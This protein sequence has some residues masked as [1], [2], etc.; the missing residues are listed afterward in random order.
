MKYI[1]LTLLSILFATQVI[2]NSPE[3]FTYQGLALD[4]NGNPFVNQNISL[5][6][7]IS[8]D[9]PQG[10]IRYQEIQS[11]TTSSKGIFSVK[12]GKGSATMATFENFASNI[13]RHALFLTIEIDPVGGSNH[14]YMGSMELLSVPFALH[15]TYSL[16]HQGAQGPNGPVGAAGADGPPGILP[17]DCCFGVGCVGDPG[18]QG[19]QG[20]IGP[21]GVPGLAG[22]SNL[23]KTN[24][25]PSNPVNGQLYMDDGS[26]RVDGNIGYRYFDVNQWIDL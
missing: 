2:A 15:A 9:S 21:S 8:R 19:P 10:E 26:N 22:L 25:P 4:A 20:P 16:N 5:K 12:V 6:F 18:P 11:A 1:F 24:T 17:P 23:V 3:G 13:G 14:K 7:S